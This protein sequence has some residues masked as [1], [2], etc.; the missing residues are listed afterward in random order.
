MGVSSMKKLLLLSFALLFVSATVFAVNFS[1]TQLKISAPAQVQYDFNGTDLHIPIT[2][3][4][5]P[6]GLNFFVY[7]K[8]EADNVKAI[9]NGFLGWHYMNHVDTCIYLS[10]Q[11]QFARGA[12]EWVWNGK[13]KN[14]NLV[15][16]GDYTYYL[17]GFDNVDP[18]TAAAP[19][20]RSLGNPINGI[21]EYGSDGAALANP[22]WL[23]DMSKWTFGQ[24]AT[25]AS[26]IE[27]C[28]L[29]LP[30]GYA[31]SSWSIV[32]LDDLNM[33]YLM[34][35]PHP[36]RDLGIVKFKWVPNGAGEVQTDWADNGWTHADEYFNGGGEQGG[37]LTD[38][39]YIYSAC[40]NL[41][42][43]EIAESQ[44]RY[45]DISDGT[46]LKMINCN[47]LWCLGGTWYTRWRLNTGPNVMSER[48]GKLLMSS[49][50]SDTYN[51]YDPLAGMD[52]ETQLYQSIN[53]NGDCVGDALVPGVLE[54][55]GPQDVYVYSYDADANMFAAF[56][57]YD[58]GAISFAIIAPDGT[59][60]Q[61][62]AFAGEVAGSKAYE[63]F[64][65]N[66][67]SFD[68]MYMDNITGGGTGTWY[69]AQDS[70]KGNLSYQIGVADN[71]PAAFT[72]AQNSPN[73]FNPTTTINYTLAKAGHVTIDVFNV[74]GQRVD[75]IVNSNMNAGSHSATW[76]ASKFSAGVYFY[77]VKS[78]DF[79]KTVKMTLLK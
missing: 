32:Q 57:C 20:D 34:A 21:V 35:G 47:D 59:G 38:G 50:N 22:L 69:I 37:L 12:G 55:C 17:W 61:Y 6:A 42:N 62:F 41:Q 48:N 1:P 77:T 18:K 79:S 23:S 76:N 60:V 11:S 45:W 44:F 5:T 24:D 75:T 33:H 26:L 31:T 13:D 28:S 51:T 25:D 53:G 43:T 29:A 66:G 65:D 40:G 67:S 58:M 56:P 72:V 9:R 52:D 4:G 39:N 71:A 74:A 14:G 36:S 70:F 73:P 10:K 30:E 15:P 54:V 19:L 46:M 64:C 49:G 3:I 27:T 78:G 7:T 2:L 8:G 16:K 63:F 68:G